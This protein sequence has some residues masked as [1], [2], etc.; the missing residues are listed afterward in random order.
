LQ[1][2]SS[3]LRLQGKRLPPE[4]SS[5]FDVAAHRLAAVCASSLDSVCFYVT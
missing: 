3:V 2:V 1:F 5:H 4:V